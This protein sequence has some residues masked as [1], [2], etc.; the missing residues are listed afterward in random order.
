[1]YSRK[2]M[3]LKD[4]DYSSSGCYFITICTKN[5]MEILSKITNAKPVGR[6]VYITPPSQTTIKTVELSDYGKIVDK[7]IR[8]IKGMDNNIS[9]DHYIIMPNHIHMI[10]TIGDN[11]AMWTSRPTTHPTT[12]MVGQRTDMAIPKL[13]RSFKTMITKEI[14]FSLWQTSYHDHIIRNEQEYLKIAN[15][16]EQNPTNWQSDCFHKTNAESVGRDVYI[17]PPSGINGFSRFS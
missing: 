7:H 4:Y 15:Y 11:G 5:R 17:T 8:V 13:I 1:M 14:G 10:V 16:I 2:Q 12:T 6:D 9:I 3:R